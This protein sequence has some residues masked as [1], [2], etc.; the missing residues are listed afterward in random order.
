MKKL[1][2]ILS[3]ST[4]L[5]NVC[6]AQ[7]SVWKIE[8]KGNTVYIGGTMHL[9]TPEDHPLPPE[10]D[11][12]YVWSDVLV[13]EAD[14]KKMENPVV[15]QQM[16][17]LAMY[18]DDRTLESELSKEAYALLEN[19]CTKI[20]LSLSGFAKFKP[21][22][23]LLIYT[24]TKLQESG[25]TEAGVDP[26]YYE[27]ALADNK[28]TLFLETVESQLELLFGDEEEDWDQAVFQFFDDQEK[29]DKMGE[30]IKDSWRSGKSK[31]LIRIQKEMKEDYPEI[32]EKVL[33]TR[34]NNWISQIS[35]YFDTESVEFVLV[36]ALHLHGPDGI[37]NLLKESG[38][39]ISQ[40]EL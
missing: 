24:V 5:L 27:K 26:Y 21:S 13:F 1:T 7:S 14:I 11:S 19:E 32:Y 31:L 29:M 40:L 18:Q 33:V 35:S 10:F 23:V 17:L 28:E 39:S 37:L 20:N 25:L 30:D 6:L 2:L 15:I 34:N 8:G 4:F 12:A 16:M 36:G 3:I 22:M 38:Y 9:L